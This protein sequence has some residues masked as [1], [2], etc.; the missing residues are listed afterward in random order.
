VSFTL[1][2]TGK[3]SGAEVAQLYLQFPAAAGEPPLQLKGFK[4][5]A[6]A[7]GAKATV[8]IPMTEKERSCF[9]PAHGGWRPAAGTFT[10]FVGG[11]S[12]RLPL[13]ATFVA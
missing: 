4:K 3:R 13:Q 7:A 1:T 9:S 12:A 5:V 10:A 6:L 2:N 11:S 8:T